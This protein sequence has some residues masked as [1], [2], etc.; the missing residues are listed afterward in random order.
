MLRYDSKDVKNIAKFVGTRN[1]TQVRTHAQKWF[2]KLRK[3]SNG[4]IDRPKSKKKRNLNKNEEEEEEEDNL[5]HESSKTDASNSKSPVNNQNFS[6]NSY[7]NL[8]S[9]NSINE[10]NSEAVKKNYFTFQE[11]ESY[12]NSKEGSVFFDILKQCKE[13]KNV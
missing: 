8:V 11:A 2:L 13:E 5:S 4:S 7:S 10:P 1:A 12:F 6:I 9:K 3:E